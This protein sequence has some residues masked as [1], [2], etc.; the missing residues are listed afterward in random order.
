MIFFF[1]Q[2][3]FLILFWAFSQVSFCHNPVF[4]PCNVPLRELDCLVH[5]ACVPVLFVRLG[6][7]PLPEGGIGVMGFSGV[8]SRPCWSYR[9]AQ[10]TQPS[11]EL[12]LWHQCWIWGW[13][14]SE[15]PGCYPTAEP[16]RCTNAGCRTW[17]PQ[18]PSEGDWICEWPRQPDMLSGITVHGLLAGLDWE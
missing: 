15:T 17:P 4:M 2:S 12:G 11:Q 6:L 7:Q 9:C 14:D 1:S 18:M 5:M 8:G 13:V 16:H 10:H 3:F